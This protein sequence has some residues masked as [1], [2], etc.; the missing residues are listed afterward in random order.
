MSGIPAIPCDYNGWH[1]RSRL[2]ARYQAVFEYFGITTL[3]EW[4]GQQLGTMWYVPDFYFPEL[5]TYFEVK[6]PHKEN[7]EKTKQLAVILK[8]REKDSS[9]DPE[10][11]ILL[12]DEQGRISGY[13]EMNDEFDLGCSLFFCKDCKRY[14]LAPNDGSFRCRWCGAYDGDHHLGCGIMYD[15]LPT[16]ILEFFKGVRF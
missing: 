12:G 1:F 3:Y 16:F 10:F 4:E 5:K 15:V 11:L 13:N 8:P 2:E 7:I 6:G 9:F 14:W